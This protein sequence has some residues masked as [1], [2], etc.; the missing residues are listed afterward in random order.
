[1]LLTDEQEAII[2]TVKN[3]NHNIIKIAAR[4]GS[5]KTSTLLET[6]KSCNPKSAIYL[7]YNTAIAKE[8][9]QKF[10]SCTNCFTIHFTNW[11]TFIIF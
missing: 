11:T 8:A 9:K 3:S 1:M 4:A 6:V 7:A 2:D 5:G 10:P